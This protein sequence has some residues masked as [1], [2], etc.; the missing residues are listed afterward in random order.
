MSS[1]IIYAT[2]LDA[3][4]IRKWIND[5]IQVA[6]ILRVHEADYHYEWKAEHEIDVLK[7]QEYALWH[8]ESGPLNV[9]SGVLG[10]ADAIVNDPFQ[11][12]VQKL[13]HS[14]A[15]RP[16]FGAN[17]PGPYCFTFAEDGFEAP[18][19]LARSEFSW[20]GDHYKS[21]GKPAHPAARKWWQKLRHFVASSTEAVPWAELSSNRKIT[22]KAYIFPDAARQIKSGRHRDI[23]PW[24]PK[25][26]A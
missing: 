22:P 8:V 23:N 20:P 7:Q 14:G 21:I 9:P 13:N 25:R 15:T 24:I 3:E 2:S 11:G 18:G 10:V 1:I 6:W 5:S 12:W 4:A 16:W 26:V 19:S 17:L